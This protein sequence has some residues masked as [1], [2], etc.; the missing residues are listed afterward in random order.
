MFPEEAYSATLGREFNMVE[1]EDAMKW[2]VLR[3]DQSTFDFTQGDRVVG[4]AY[5]HRMK[6]RGHTLVWDGP[7]LPG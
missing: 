2:C 1:A 7:I 6:V 5:T 3:P 4:F